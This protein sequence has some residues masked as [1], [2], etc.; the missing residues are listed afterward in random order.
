MFREEYHKANDNIRVNYELLEKI[1]NTKTKKRK[2][3]Y[4]HITVAASVMI[5]AVT[6]LTYPKLK[7]TK[8]PENNPVPVVENVVNE[9]KVQTPTITEEPRNESGEKDFEYKDNQNTVVVKPDKTEADKKDYKKASRAVAKEEKVIVETAETPKP[10]PEEL[11]NSQVEKASEIIVNS[12]TETQ[13]KASRGFLLFR[14][15]V[16]PWQLRWEP[17]MWPV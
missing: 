9:T 2:S 7:I 16:Q 11:K 6:L 12:E 10:Y 17:E 3:F 4:P 15:C 5:V 1:K 14:Q 13:G 8:E